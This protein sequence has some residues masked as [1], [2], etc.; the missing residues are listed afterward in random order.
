MAALGRWCRPV[1]AVRK[2]S[3]LAGRKEQFFC[4][5][6]AAARNFAALGEP[7]PLP[8]CSLPSAQ[9]CLPPSSCTSATWSCSP[10]LGVL[11]SLG[12]GVLFGLARA[13]LL[14]D[15]LPRRVFT[16]WL[17]KVTT[18]GRTHSGLGF[19]QDPST[20]CSAPLP[21]VDPTSPSHASRSVPLQHSH[22]A[23]TAAH[24][25]SVVAWIPLNACQSAQRAESELFKLHLLKDPWCLF[26][27]FVFSNSLKSS[28]VLQWCFVFLFLHPTYKSWMMHIKHIKWVSEGLCTMCV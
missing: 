24:Y 15:S 11:P 27:L 2:K 9:S 17:M 26:L 21:P 12:D 8:S 7:Q 22:A 20:H 10:S 4:K 1:L 6:W 5:E 16:P 3:L 14:S 18:G 28:F 13:V 23:Q 19:T 25:Y